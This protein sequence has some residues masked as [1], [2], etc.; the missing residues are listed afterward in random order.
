VSSTR[1]VRLIHSSGHA[2]V[3]NTV[4]LRDVGITMVTDEPPGATIDRDPET[5][6]PTGLLF[7]MEWW[8][9]SR[10]PAASRPSP[11]ATARRASSALLAA[12]VTTVVDAGHR[13]SARRIEHYAEWQEAAAFVP[14]TQVMLAPGTDR[15]DL[16]EVDRVTAGATKLMLATSGGR[17]NYNTH[18]IAEIA[19]QSIAEGS[20]G[21]AVHAI[22]A[23]TI[24][25]VCEALA[26]PATPGFIRRVEH[27]S[28]ASV[29]AITALKQ[30]G[31][32]VV[33]QPGFIWRRGE[34][35]LSAEL[36]SDAV[37]G[38]LYPMSA[39]RDSGVPL[40][41]GSDA[42]YGPH[43][44]FLAV[45]SAVDRLT[46]NTDVLGPDQAIGPEEGLHLYGPAAASA[47]GLS[48]VAGHLAPGMPADFV[49]LDGN[50]L[51]ATGPQLRQMN[52]LE[53]WI[54]GRRLWPAD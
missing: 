35:Y 22:E 27:A 3:L 37:V 45:A 11:G 44:P 7:E 10:I 47:S 51:D 42:P 1:P 30:S 14:R 20:P 33:T 25:E 28:E 48:E 21:I 13:N 50:L 6:E 52:V 36:A 26:G 54:S 46:E 53:T 4:A 40:A 41:A 39:L 34:R 43:E 19:R 49:I 2:E 29:G 23:D 31:I 38:D 16:P 9:S 24:R 17:P 5:G 12:G 18:E 8:V 32:T 15:T